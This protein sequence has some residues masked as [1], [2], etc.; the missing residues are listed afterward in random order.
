VS[1]SRELHHQTI[2]TNESKKNA[3]FIRKVAVELYG[4][5]VENFTKVDNGVLA[6]ILQIRICFNIS[7]G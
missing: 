1:E 7:L 6:V 4:M 2:T 3:N 5:R